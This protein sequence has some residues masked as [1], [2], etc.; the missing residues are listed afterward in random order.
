MTQGSDIVGDIDESGCVELLARMVRFDSTRGSSGESELARFLVDRMGEMGLEATLQPVE[1]GRFNA[2][3]VWRGTGGGPTLLFNGH[4]DTN[5]VTEGWTV[6]PWGGLVRDGCLYGIGASNMKAGD[7]AAFCAVRTLIERGARPAG[8]VILSFVVGELDGG[9]GTLEALGRGLR[10]DWF[11]NCEPTDLRALTVHAGAMNFVVELTG[12]TRHVSKRREAVDALAAACALVPRIDGASFLGAAGRAHQALSRAHVGA[13]RAGLTREFSEARPPQV[14]D[15]ARLVGTARYAPGESEASVLA[16][17][18]GMVEQLRG[19]YQGLSA[20]V[21][22]QPRPP[23]WPAMLPFEVA[24]DAGIVRAVNRA[25]RAVRGAPQPTGAIEPACWFWTDAA[26]LLHSGHME[27]VVCGPGG[28][29]NTMP[30][31]R[32]ELADYLDAVRIYA[33][34]ILDVCGQAGVQPAQRKE[35]PEHPRQDSNL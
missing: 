12:A 33:L 31:E 13:L 20:E 16:D 27:G 5:P 9:I 14:A 21:F 25:Y 35:A 1:P 4:I 32:V 24:G 23:G 11:V 19:E 7:A 2:L 15:F 17:L 26:H 8:D 34:V 6:D 28:R 22:A 18:R 10:A 3:G 29:Y 30:D